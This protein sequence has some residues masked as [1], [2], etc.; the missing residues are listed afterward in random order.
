[1]KIHVRKLGDFTKPVIQFAEDAGIAEDTVDAEDTQYNRRAFVRA[2]FAMIE[3]TV[4]FL[5]QTVFST[6]SS[7]G[8]RLRVE[9]AL[10]LQDSSVDLSANGKQQIKTKFLRSIRI[11]NVCKF[12]FPIS[13]LSSQEYVSEVFD[14]ETQWSLAR[15]YKHARYCFY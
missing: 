9:E 2:L 10:L 5:K 12:T 3:G 11:L 6:G 1:M 15:S 14:N 8:N 13:N 4:F 7:G